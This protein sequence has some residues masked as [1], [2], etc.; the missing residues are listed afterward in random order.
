[1]SLTHIEGTRKPPPIEIKKKTSNE[2]RK[3][4]IG[5]QNMLFLNER[6]NYIAGIMVRVW[7]NVGS[8]LGLVYTKDSKT[9]YF[10]TT[11]HMHAAL[12]SA[13]KNWL[14]RSQD[15]VVTESG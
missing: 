13:I 5:K 2:L 14:A 12:M 9:G 7:F 6:S 3:I 10:T 8:N 15:N 1:M 4:S 11:M